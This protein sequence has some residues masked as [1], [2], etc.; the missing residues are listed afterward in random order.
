MGREESKNNKKTGNIIISERGPER[1]CPRS[2]IDEECYRVVGRIKKKK[3]EREGGR[4]GREKK[5]TR[6]AAT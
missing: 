5:N 3:R 4:G 6:S 2:E 1:N